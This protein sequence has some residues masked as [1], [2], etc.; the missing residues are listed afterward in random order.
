[1]ECK[2]RIKHDTKSLYLLI[3]AIIHFIHNHISPGNLST[4]YP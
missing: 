4:E 3:R 1:M 2:K